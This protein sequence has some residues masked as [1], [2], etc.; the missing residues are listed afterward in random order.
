MTELYIDDALFSKKAVFAGV[1]RNGELI[2][3]PLSIEVQYS[4]INAHP[5]RGTIHGTST[6]YKSLEHFFMR[7]TETVCLLESISSSA[8]RERITCK[9]VLIREISER[10]YADDE[11]GLIQ[12]TIGRFVVDE[13]HIEHEIP[14][15]TQPKQEA[16]FSLDGPTLL[17]MSDDLRSLSYTG[18]VT[19]KVRGGDLV[20]NSLPG[21]RIQAR[22][23]FH[24]ISQGDGQSDELTKDSRGRRSLAETEIFVLTISQSDISQEI[25]NFQEVASRV[26]ERLCL[27]VSFLSKRHVRCF[28]RTFV[29]TTRLT[30]IYSSISPGRRDAPQWE[31]VIL[32]PAEIQSFIQNAFE[33][34]DEQSRNGIDIRLPILAYIHAQNAQFVDYEF[35]SLFRSLEMLVDALDSSKQAKPLVSKEDLLQLKKVLRTELKRMN[36]TKNDRKAIYE[37]LPELQRPNFLTRVTSHLEHALVDLEDIGGFRGIEKTIQI[38]NLLIH[39]AQEPC[40]DEIANEISRL[41]TIVERLILR[42][43]GW[44]GRTHTPTLNNWRQLVGEMERV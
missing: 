19:T 29:S 39:S 41:E 11:T 3:P 22:P 35:L 30:E 4:P 18:N 13:L 12:Q 33:R 6:E 31:D 17:W 9:G 20:L 34:Y 7:R 10:R 32:A 38:R 42:L 23:H 15:S 27:L 44:A 26:N 40:M 36:K 43:L 25:P 14:D 8:G 5:P 2:T 28:S 24:Y 37:K 21:L 1:F 16:I